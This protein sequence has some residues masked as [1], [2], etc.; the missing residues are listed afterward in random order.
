MEPGRELFY[1]ETREDAPSLV[2]ASIATSP[3]LAVTAR[4]RLFPIEPEK[5]KGVIAQ[6]ILTTSGE[7]GL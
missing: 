1:R 7:F 5:V 2:A 6:T 3:T 4:K